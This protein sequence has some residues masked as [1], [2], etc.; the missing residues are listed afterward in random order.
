MD[1]MSIEESAKTLEM[2][3]TKK[4]RDDFFTQLK[5]RYPLFYITT[6]EER[7]FNVF[8]EHFCRVNGYT[9][10]LWDCFR[11]LIELESNE[12]AGGTDDTI[13]LPN[14]ILEFIRDESSRLASDDDNKTN[15]TK[16]GKRGVIFVLQDFFRFID[17]RHRTPQWDIERRLKSLINIEGVV[18]TIITGPRYAVPEVLENLI[19][20]ID[21]PYPNKN[22]IKNILWGAVSSVEAMG[23]DLR[24]ETIEMEEDLV[25]SVSGLTLL[26][27]QTA[28]AKS[29][30]LNKSWNIPTL[31]QEKK[32]IIAKSGMLEFYDKT[33]DITEIGGLK[34]LKQWIVE[35]KHCFGEEAKEYGLPLPKGFLT[36]GMPGCGK[37]LTCKA[38]SSLW[39]MPLLRLD[40][41]K[42]FHSHI[43]ASEE[44]IRNAIK[45][46]E[47]VAPC[48]LW[49]DEIEKGI[50]GV[51][52]SGSTDGGTSSRVFSTFLTWMQEKDAPVFVVATANDY[53]SIPAEFLR[54]G[55]FDEIFF[56]NIPNR[57]EREEIFVVQL[58]GKGHNPDD[59]DVVELS[60]LTKNYSG[61]EIEKAIDKAMLVGF[62]DG[63]RAI[64]TEDIKVSIKAF[65][66]LAEQRADEFEGMSEWAEANCVSASEEE[67][68]LGK[69]HYGMKKMDGIDLT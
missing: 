54:A 57:K 10:Y 64:T 25:N 68:V 6:H 16:R 34:N 48:I 36:I 40:F 13:R 47:T 42:M 1:E 32:Q 46:A 51:R 17:P 53:T 14:P 18:S 63:K 59:F 62:A 44:N 33:V 12:P 39:Q 22:E 28:F 2:M 56:V 4:F 43:G 69:E 52:S 29:L 26:E 45:L 9:C 23:L 30:V 5:A 38:V 67:G 61:A 50:S 60:N 37:S 15:L 20:T 7:R 19:P 24:D 66:P 55:R 31:L 27:S 41:G 8:L 35:R 58:Q 49:I 11:G 21:F 65:K 3:A